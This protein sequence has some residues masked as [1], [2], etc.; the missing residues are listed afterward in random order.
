MILIR[1]YV[2]HTNIIQSPTAL[3]LR[4]RVAD[5]ALPPVAYLMYMMDPLLSSLFHP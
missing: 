2:R 5:L 4:V 1:S 3:T